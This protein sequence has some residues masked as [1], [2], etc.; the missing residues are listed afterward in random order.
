[1]GR[2]RKAVTRPELSRFRLSATVVHRRTVAILVT[3]LRGTRDRMSGV[4]GRAPER[5][6]VPIP[7]LKVPQPWQVGNVTVHPGDSAADLLADTPAF[8][9]PDNLI[10]EKVSEILATAFAGSAAE[11]KGVADIEQ[12][13]ETVRASI[14]ALRLFQLARR[15]WT[16]STFGLPGDLHS[17]LIEYIAVWENAVR[18]PIERRPR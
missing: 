1:M 18:S 16:E 10:R 13:L 8:D 4:S 2:V 3:L 11:V 9:T 12:A 17:S 6:L 14:S 5:F 7:S 15:K